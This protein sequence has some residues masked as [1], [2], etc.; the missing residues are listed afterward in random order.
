MPTRPERYRPPRAPAEAFVY[1][2]RWRKVRRKKL[3]RD[4]LCELCLMTGERHTPA[5]LVHHVLPIS[6]G[7]APYVL[8]N[9]ESLCKSCH[10]KRHG[11]VR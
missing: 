9:M 6:Q 2:E 3:A 4:P 5:T 11:E 7:G 10:V 8:A 1:G